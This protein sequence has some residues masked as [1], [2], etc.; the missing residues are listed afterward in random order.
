M[1]AQVELLWSKD[2]LSNFPDFFF[3]LA[4][5]LYFHTFHFFSPNIGLRSVQNI[6][7][8]VKFPNFEN[9][10]YPNFENVSCFSWKTKEENLE[11]KL[12]DKNGP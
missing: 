4:I 8:S 1:L 11:K 6:L 12:L 3:S 10:K 2:F 7:P 9:V 5:F